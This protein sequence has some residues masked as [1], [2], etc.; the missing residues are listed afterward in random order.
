MINKFYKTLSISENMNLFKIQVN[1]LKKRN[2]NFKNVSYETIENF[3][4]LE[5]YL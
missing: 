5:Q 1:F 2:P 3:S 4:S